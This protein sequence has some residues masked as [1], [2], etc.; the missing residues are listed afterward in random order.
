MEAVVHATM[1]DTKKLVPEWIAAGLCVVF[2]FCGIAAAQPR[3][4]TTVVKLPS[5]VAKSDPLAQQNLSFD[6]SFARE[7][8]DY[9]HSPNPKLLDSMADSPAITHILNHARNF[10]YDVPKDSRTALVSSL[11]GPED[12]QAARLATC[13][14][15]LAY[16]SGPMLADPHWV[17]DDLRYLPADFRYNGTLFV[18]FG[19]DIG[20]AF[21]A[22]ASLNCTHPRFG[23]HPRELLYYAIHELHHVGFMHYQP[24]PKLSDIKTCAEL[25]KLVEYS[26]QLEGMGVLAA[27]QRRSEEHALADDPDYV[28]LQD[29]KRM[30]ADLESYFKDYDYLVGRGNQAADPDAWAVIHRMSP[31]ERLWYR[32]GAYMAQRIESAKG[33]AALIALIKEGPSQFILTY[34][35]LKQFRS[36]YRPAEYASRLVHQLPI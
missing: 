6:A 35:S 9:V 12:K 21:G 33:R 28:A 3:S 30:Q 36:F 10:D 26:T 1:L 2:A 15:A 17:N 31:G 27:Y 24:P 29:E 16:F 14:H 8:I 25:L 19:Y 34:K 20:V 32:V 5:L 18:T 22:N 13:E 11:L 4:T 7:A 23:E